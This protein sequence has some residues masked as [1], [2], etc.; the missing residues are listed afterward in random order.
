[1]PSR[2]GTR[3]L[4][5]VFGSRARA[6]QHTVE[7]NRDVTNLDKERGKVESNSKAQEDAKGRSNL[8]ERENNPITA[9]VS[10]LYG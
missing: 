8:N 3:C 1:M 2:G 5:D 4:F 10:V 7:T 9:D 6:K